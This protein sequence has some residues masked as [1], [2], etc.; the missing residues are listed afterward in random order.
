MEIR[1]LRNS[2][3]KFSDILINLSS[4]S[5]SKFS[6]ISFDNGTLNDKNLDNQSIELQRARNQNTRTHARLVMQQHA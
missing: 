5:N 1:V 3:P 4:I 2:S 6:T